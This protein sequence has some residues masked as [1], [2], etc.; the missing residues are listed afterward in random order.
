MFK[1]LFS[2]K[3]R[4]S[5]K[6]I[7]IVSLIS[8]L[9]LFLLGLVLNDFPQTANNF[10]FQAIV[11][12]ISFTILW[13]NFAASVKRWHDRNKSGFYVLIQLIPIIGSIWALI[14]LGFLPAKENNRF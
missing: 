4:M 11:T 13:I 5:R 3:G 1:L 2:P 7:W 9:V 6:G 14:E 8:L 10:L 12:I